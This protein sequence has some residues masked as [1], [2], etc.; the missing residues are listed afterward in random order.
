MNISLVLFLSMLLVN[1]ANAQHSQYNE[2]EAKFYANY[3]KL[4]GCA[5][6][7]LIINL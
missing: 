1:S 4:V 3:S 2:A 6:K 7:P 5:Q